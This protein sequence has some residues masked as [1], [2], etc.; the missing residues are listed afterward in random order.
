MRVA[1]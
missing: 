1:M